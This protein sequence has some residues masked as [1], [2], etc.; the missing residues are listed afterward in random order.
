MLE[1]TIKEL[2]ERLAH[3]ILRVE[4][5]EEI[6]IIRR[7]KVVA[8]LAPPTPAQTSFPD[9]SEFRAGI[10]LTGNGISETVI[11]ERRERRY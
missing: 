11:A 2:R 4:A 3:Y 6:V 9:L 10:A 5:G 1:V 8:H 7:G